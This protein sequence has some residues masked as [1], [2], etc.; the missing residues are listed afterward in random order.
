MSK[1]K[2]KYFNEHRGWGIIG[3]SELEE[4]VYVHYTAIRMKGYKT[5][6]RGQEVYFELLKSPQGLMASNVTVG[7]S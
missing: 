1:G 7:F 2:V 3:N 4:D 6:K 5:L